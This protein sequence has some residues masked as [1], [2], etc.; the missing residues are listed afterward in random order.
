MRKVA[1]EL[2]VRYVLEGS[3]RRV[4]NEVRIN[5]QLIDATT[6]GHVWAER[7]DGSLD[8]IFGLQ[9]DVTH[10]IVSVLAVQ[11]TAGEQEQIALRGTEHTE[12]YDVFLKGWEQYL[13]QTAEGFREAIT[14]FENAVELDPNYSRA[15][16]AMAATY[17][18]IYKRFWHAKFGF[19]RVHNARFKAEE[20]LEKA[21]QQPTSL[22]YQ[23][24]VAMLSQQGRHTEALAEGG[25]AIGVDPNDADSYVALAGALSMAGNPS[26]AL[27]LIQKAMRLNPHFPPFY[28]YDLGLAQ[29][30]TGDF[31]SAAATFEKATALNPEDRWSSRL[32]VASYG[33]LGRQADAERIGKVLAKNWRGYDPMN[34]R[35]V[36]FWY[37]FK[38]PE[39][40]ERLAAGLRKANVPD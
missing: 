26:E 15:Y 20:L 3:V 11:L 33:H 29:F 4:G 39:D 7:Y 38:R 9:D 36:A 22:S 31:G 28:L 13:H 1:E 8:D 37:P 17:W 35:A 21:R 34:I 16:A 10:K 30:G 14:H 25:K 23:V 24:A 5:A 2:G 18:Q 27:Q 6:G 19:G 12:A 40:S 32:L